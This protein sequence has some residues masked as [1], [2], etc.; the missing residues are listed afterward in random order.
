[1]V[2]AF[3]HVPI[4]GL[5]VSGLVV[6]GLLTLVGCQIDSA[7]LGPLE[8]TPPMVGDAGQMGEMAEMAEDSLQDN[9]FGPVARAALPELALEREPQ[10]ADAG[11]QDLGSAPD[12]DVPPD[13]ELFG[14]DAGA[15]VDAGRAD[16][17]TDSGGGSASGEGGEGGSRDCDG[18]VDEGGGDKC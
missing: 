1:M 18:E 17:G 2:G 13:P 3:L 7:G 16:T 12:G 10:P 14:A 11:A 6:F 5:P 8:E 15:P 9:P 4:R